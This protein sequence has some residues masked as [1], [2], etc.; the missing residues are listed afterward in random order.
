LTIQTSCRHKLLNAL[1]EKG[2]DLVSRGRSSTCPSVVTLILKE[3]NEQE[4]DGGTKCSRQ[5]EQC[6]PRPWKE[7]ELT[8]IK[9][10]LLQWGHFG[11]CPPLALA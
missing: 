1:I 6:V 5:K 7:K 2:L 9:P 8:D 4:R 11:F 3:E 10:I